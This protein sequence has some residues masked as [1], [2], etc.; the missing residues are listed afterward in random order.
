MGLAAL[1]L[2]VTAILGATIYGPYSRRVRRTVYLASAQMG[3]LF[4]RKEH[5][6]VLAVALAWTGAVLHFLPADG[7]L[8]RARS[9]RVALTAA[10]LLSAMVAALGTRVAAFVSFP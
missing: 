3:L 10:A 2:T 9:V 6:A 7:S 1:L 5:L 8:A 4:E